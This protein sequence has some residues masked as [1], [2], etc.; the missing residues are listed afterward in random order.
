MISIF[1]INNRDRMEQLS[2]PL[3]SNLLTNT[4]K[5]HIKVYVRTRPLLEKEILEGAEDILKIIPTENKILVEEGSKGCFTFDGVCDENESQ[6]EV[7]DK[8]VYP[9]LKNLD[10]IKNVNIIAYGQTGSGKTYTI[11]TNPFYSQVFW[12]PKCE[13]IFGCSNPVSKDKF[14]DLYFFLNFSIDHSFDIVCH[15]LSTFSLFQ[16]EENGGMLQRVMS[17]LLQKQVSENTPERYLKMTFLEIYNEN[18]YDLFASRKILET[19]ADGFG[20]LIP[21]N[22]K[23]EIILTSEE[24]LTL[25]EKG[26]NVRSAA[27]TAMNPHSSRSH[28]VISVTLFEKLA[29]GVSVP[30]GCLRMVDL[31]GAEGVGRNNT[32]GKNFSEGVSINKGLLAVGKVLAALSNNSASL[33]IP[34]RESIVTRLLKD[35][36]SGTDCS[37]AMIVCVSPAS[38]NLSV[39]L[40]TLRYAEQARNIKIKQK[41]STVKKRNSSKRRFDD[42]SA[43]PAAWKRF[44]SEKKRTPFHNSTISTPGHKPSVRRIQPLNCTFDT[45]PNRAR[46]RTKL[47]PRSSSR[48]DLKSISEFS[49][50]KQPTFDEE[51]SPANS[52]IGAPSVNTT[53]FQMSPLVERMNSRFEQSILQYEERLKSMENKFAKKVAKIIMKGTKLKRRSKRLM[54]KKVKSPANKEMPSD[55]SLSVSSSS[56]DENEENSAVGGPFIFDGNHT[57][58]PLTEISNVNDSTIRKP[59]RDKNRRPVTSTV[60]DNDKIMRRSTRLSCRKSQNEISFSHMKISQNSDSVSDETFVSFEKSED[61]TIIFTNDY[62]TSGSPV[63]R[64]NNVNSNED[65][66]TLNSVTGISSVANK[67]CSNTRR[68]STRQSALNAQK[69]I[70]TSC[71][72]LSKNSPLT[73]TSRRKYARQ[74]GYKVSNKSLNGS[75]YF[76]GLKTP[77]KCSENLD[78]TVDFSVQKEHKD[79]ILYLLNNADLRKLQTLPTVGPKTAMVIYN[80]RK[81]FGKLK[82]V[83]DLQNIPG[84]TKSFYTRF[85]KVIILIFFFV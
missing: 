32:E 52:I 53:I 84:L 22:C 83:E 38:T 25:L 61:T 81:M 58:L 45:P 15:C 2:T 17:S 5:S 50:F 46:D 80:F 1:E 33:H 39:T 70:K 49:S 56:N 67:A 28:A 60:V 51:L 66:Q 76:A 24:G 71:E 59:L 62:L 78:L 23:D 75:V 42:L 18:I 47:F 40:S 21:L 74:S 36:L 14:A 54:K 12:F 63:L 26:N 48:S 65:S 37:T 72:I 43:H 85:I 77:M 19:K 29:N 31:A 6:E 3:H 20:G 27:S 68:R 35:A 7:F 11:G 64:T 69:A 10:S 8:V 13:E 55:I 30:K 4:A 82:S 44:A 73:T 34:Y 16:K 41:L 79:H 9:L 57:R